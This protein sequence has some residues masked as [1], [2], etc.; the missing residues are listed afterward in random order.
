MGTSDLLTHGIERRSFA[1]RGLQLSYLDSAPNDRARP[2]ILLLHGFPDEAEMWLPLI[3]AL[4]AAGFRVLAPDTVGCGQSAMAAQTSD[5]DVFS[6]LDDLCGLLDHLSVPKVY[7]AGHDWGSG[8][9]WFLAMHRPQRVLRL[10]AISV[11]HPAAYAGAGLRQKLMGWYIAY[12]HL[13]AIAERLL[14]GRGYFSLRRVF[15]SHPDIEGVMA[16]LAVPGRLTAALRLYRA[17]VL[18]HIL[19]SEHPRAKVPVLGIHSADDAF[20]DAGQMRDSGD[21]TDSA[22]RYVALDGGHWLPLEQPQRIAGLMLEH[23]SQ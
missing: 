23:F 14:P 6:I 16:R 7:L 21:W 10:C 9:A 20:L 22:F 11:G 18:Q 13:V 3:P 4:H 17:N 1:R 8:I 5:Y 2:V 12:F 19:F 15:G